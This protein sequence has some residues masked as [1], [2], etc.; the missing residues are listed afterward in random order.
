MATFLTRETLFLSGALLLFVLLAI[1]LYNGLVQARAR[2]LEAWA[3]IEVQLKRRADLVPNL[4]SAVKGYAAHERRVLDEVAQTRAAVEAAPGPAAAGRAN[5][6]LNAALVTLL[7]IGESY[8]NLQAS[9]NF[10]ELQQELADV[11]EK[12]AYARRFYNQSAQEYNIR[13]LSIPGLLVARLCRFGPME[14]FQAESTDRESVHV[15]T[16]IPG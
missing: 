3:G 16:G 10:L 4:V 14:Y 9:D 6:A 7:A 12:I 5:Q 1:L 2:T 8:P 15:S 13:I 11:E